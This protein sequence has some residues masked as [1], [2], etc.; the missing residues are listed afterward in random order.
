M[1]GCFAAV[2][3][4]L[5]LIDPY[6]T[7]RSPLWRKPWLKGQ[8]TGDA[9]ASVGRNPN[10]TGAIIGN[11][12]IALIRP[13]RLTKHTGIPFAQ[14]SIPAAPIRGQLTILD[15]FVRNHPA[16][17]E[18]LVLSIDRGTWCT[19]DPN[20]P[21][22]KPFPFWR[23][24]R[25]T[26]EYL[27]GLVSLTSAAQ[28]FQSFATRRSTKVTGDDGFWDYEPM[29]EPLMRNP[30]QRQKE[31]FGKL[32]DQHGNTVAPFPAADALE[33]ELK[34]VPAHTTII[35]AMP[36]V[37]TARQPAPG[38]PRDASEQ[39]CRKRFY[40]LASRR[41]GTALVDWWD[42][43]PEFK[44]TNLF[45]DQIHIRR[46]LADHFEEAIIMA[47]Q[48]MKTSEIHLQTEPR[49]LFSSVN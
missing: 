8:R 31:L 24:S 43:R 5:F 44:D 22:D 4:A 11:S 40:E 49:S 2:V 19:R 25:S 45:I 12:T 47:L 30:A 18:A 32:N 37:F 3:G 42:D 35:L 23:Y 26:M 21:S 41:P 9:T 29:Y 33:A 1:I 28:A 7:G 27:T 13:S 15:W 36:P 20:L 6:D 34:S 46:A 39:A 38:T 14:L 16:K 17:T 10:F 48:R